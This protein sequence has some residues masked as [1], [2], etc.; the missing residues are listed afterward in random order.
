MKIEIITTANDDYKE[1]GFG[2]LKACKSVLKSIEKLGHEV[3]LNVCETQS[4]LDDIVRTK[5]DL[6]ILAVK[7]ISIKD[8][9]DI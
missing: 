5:P 8:E 1:T 7:Y 4:S 3:R 9:D 2:T 6:A